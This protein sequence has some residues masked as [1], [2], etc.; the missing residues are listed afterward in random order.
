[1]LFSLSPCSTHPDIL[2]SSVKYM[3][4][5]IG[6]KLPKGSQIKLLQIVYNMALH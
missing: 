6:E 1:M 4:G 2:Q 5:H 3:E